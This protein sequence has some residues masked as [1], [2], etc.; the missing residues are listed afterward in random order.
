MKKKLTNTVFKNV[1]AK[2]YPVSM[3]MNSYEEVILFIFEGFP[4]MKSFTEDM[5]EAEVA[6]VKDL[7]RDCLKKNHPDEPLRLRGTGVVGWGTK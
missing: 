3:P 1:Q 4:F 6:K 5:D 2:E 7:M